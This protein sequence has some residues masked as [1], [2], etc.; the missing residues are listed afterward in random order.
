LSGASGFARV[1]GYRDPVVQNS[2]YNWQFGPDGAGG[3]EIYEIKQKGGWFRSDKRWTEYGELSDEML[4]QI[5]EFWQGIGDGMSAA[6]RQLG[7]DVPEM[8]EASF[9]EMYDRKG[10]LKSTI[11]TILGRTYEE[12]WEEISQRIAAESIIAVVAAAVGDV[13]GSLPGTG[14]AAA[15]AIAGAGGEAGIV[16][17]GGPGTRPQIKTGELAE[18]GQAMANE[19]QLLAERWRDSADTLLDGAQL[20]LAAQT[21]IQRG[22]SLIDA[23]GP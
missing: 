16:R 22:R 19:A 14:G 6:A 1:W 20:L 23:T 5:S 10:N 2:G 3:Q 9:T 13:P 7:V 17:G 21:D 12:S 4:D 11:G 8:I 15:D 18:A